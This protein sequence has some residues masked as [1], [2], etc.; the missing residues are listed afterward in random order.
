M[1]K[2]WLLVS[3]YFNS[4][5][6]LTQMNPKASLLLIR[7]WPFCEQGF[8]KKHTQRLVGAQGLGVFHTMLN[9]MEHEMDTAT[10][11]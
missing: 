3:N 6:E 10:N 2:P 9:K 5:S 4:D 11:S 8:L 7:S 1:Y